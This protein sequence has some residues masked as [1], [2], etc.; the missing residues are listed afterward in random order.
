[1]MIPRAPAHGSDIHRLGTPRILVQEAMASLLANH[2]SLP[3]VGCWRL[4]THLPH[5]GAAASF[6]SHVTTAP[7][8]ED[9]HA[10]PES[11]LW[12]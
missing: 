7:C 2:L 4:S 5:P 9:S 1:M 3:S 8:V 12:Q 11:D 10:F 6:L